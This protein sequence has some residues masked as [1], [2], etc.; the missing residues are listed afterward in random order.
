MQDLSRIV[1]FFL[2][3]DK[4]QPAHKNQKEILERDTAVRRTSV[5]LK[6]LSMKFIPSLYVVIGQLSYSDKDSRMYVNDSHSCCSP[7]GFAH[8]GALIFAFWPPDV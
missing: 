8:F 3:Y 6:T 5:L 2:Q 1:F 7:T 4:F